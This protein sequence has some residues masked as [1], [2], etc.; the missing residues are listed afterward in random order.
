MA[1]EDWSPPNGCLPSCHFVVVRPSRP[2]RRS[3]SVL[4]IAPLSELM[5]VGVAASDGGLCKRLYGG[6]GVLALWSF[7]WR[8]AR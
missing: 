8:G 5:D 4:S 7:G 1:M 6:A 3:C 2:S